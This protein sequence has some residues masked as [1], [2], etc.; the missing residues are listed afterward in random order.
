MHKHKRMSRA[1]RDGLGE[2]TARRWNGRGKHGYYRYGKPSGRQR[3]GHVAEKP[4]DLC[5]Q[6]VLDYSEPGETVFDPFCGA[7]S[8]GVAAILEGRS[9]L[10]IDNNKEWVE[11]SRMRLSNT[12]PNAIETKK[13]GVR[14]D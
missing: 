4:V 2:M 3:V 10:G 1:I 8:I 6:L 5:R 7:G 9:Y 11:K 13:C 14:E 12:T